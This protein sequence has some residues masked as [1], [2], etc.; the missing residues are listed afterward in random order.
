MTCNYRHNYSPNE[1]VTDIIFD[2]YDNVPYLLTKC[3]VNSNL[4]QSTSQNVTGSLLYT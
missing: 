2:D 4:Y 1:I 3:V